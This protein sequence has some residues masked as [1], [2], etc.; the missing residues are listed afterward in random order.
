MS[1]LVWKLEEFM[2][3]LDGVEFKAYPYSKMGR[4]I[5]IPVIE[6]KL[7]LVGFVLRPEAQ[8]YVCIENLRYTLTKIGC[9]MSDLSIIKCY[10]T[11]SRNLMRFKSIF[12]KL[13]PE[14]NIL[15]ENIG[16][17]SLKS[18]DQVVELKCVVLN[19][20]CNNLINE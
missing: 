8:F 4:F 18:W 17:T 3:S 20:S 9:T 1:K 6:G 16:V 7:P 14:V 10:Y 12:L 19:R 15:W 2:E 5:Y 11:S 13:Y